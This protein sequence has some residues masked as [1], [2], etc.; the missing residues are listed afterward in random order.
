[1]AHGWKEEGTV[2]AAG[3][4]AWRICNRLACGRESG[5]ALAAA[6][7]AAC[8]GGADA[9]AAEAAWEGGTPFA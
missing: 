3:G 7:D 6:G 4:A 2:V 9:A 5:Q 8:K 1:M